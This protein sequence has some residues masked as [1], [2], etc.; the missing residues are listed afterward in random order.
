MALM[1]RL[2]YLP[3][4]LVGLAT[5]VSSSAQRCLSTT[6]TGSMNLPANSVMYLDVNIKR[7]LT[8]TGLDVHLRSG[9]RGA[10]IYVYRTDG[11]WQGKENSSVGWELVVNRA[12]ISNPRP[13]G[14]ASTVSLPKPLAMPTGRYGLAFVYV[15]DGQEFTD[16]LFPLGRVAASNG[17]LDIHEGGAGT[18]LYMGLCCAPR[19]WN[20]RICYTLG[21]KFSSATPYGTGCPASRPMTLES[22]APPIAGTKTYVVAHTPPVSLAN[23]LVLSSR[24]IFPGIQPV[25]GMN[26]CELYVGLDLTVPLPAGG[27]GAVGL[28]VTVPI[29]AVG[30]SVYWQAIALAPINP[31]GAAF[32]NGLH[33]QIEA[34]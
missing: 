29:A 30:A 28:V 9:N 1:N 26:T 33:W 24:R 16:G 14:S 15:G 19:V 22:P 20:G 10:A 6:F 12:E 2:G 31:L 5:S 18:A 23:I 21:T 13:A 34:N 32:S 3:V 17:D 27:G 25:P 8:I 4:L 11:T 7:D